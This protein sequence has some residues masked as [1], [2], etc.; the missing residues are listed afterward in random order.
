MVCFRSKIAG[1]FRLL[2]LIIANFVLIY[3]GTS[4]LHIALAHHEY[5][6][7]DGGG[8]C[9]QTQNWNPNAH[10]LT[11]IYFKFTNGDH[12][13]KDI[14][15]LRGSSDTTTNFQDHNCDDPYEYSFTYEPV[16]GPL[17]FEEAQGNCL[18]ECVIGLTPPPN[19]TFLLRGFSFTFVSGDKNIKRIGLFPSSMD[20]RLTVIMQDRQVDSDDQFTYRIQYI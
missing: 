8:S 2:T 12:K 19:H 11:Q 6:H 14:G 10:A 9:L 16:P 4:R 3:L 13:L 5:N 1:Q 7:I 20:T 17:R 18:G 15:I